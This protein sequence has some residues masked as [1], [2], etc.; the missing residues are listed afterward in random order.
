MNPTLYDVFRA[1]RNPSVFA[2]GIL[3]T[4]LAVVVLALVLSNVAQNSSN[5]SAA[6]TGIGIDVIGGI[7]GFFV[8][9]IGLVIGNAVYAKDRSTGVM[10]SVLCRP[11]TR[12]ELVISRFLALVLSS[13][14]ILAAALFVTDLAVVARTGY[15]ID[16]VALAAIFLSLLV[17]AASFGGL[18]MF[19]SHVFRSGST[20]Q[21]A[22]TTI[23]VIFSIVWYI[24]LIIL[25]AAEN[26]LTDAF[27]T[28]FIAD[29][30]SPAQYTILMTA[31]VQHTFLFGI[32][33]IN[34]A[35][36]G[37]VLGGLVAGGLAW[38]LG[39]FA[40]TYY[41]ATHRD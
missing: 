27:Q 28:M 31:Y 3:T 19:L 21:G 20:V 41:L 37:L 7:F 34:P 29:Y 25:V 17:E 30:F 32:L 5:L 10:D 23:F 14:A 2:M 35:N 11:V 15:F 9:V 4:L 18:I 16:P 8:P 13:G 40:A 26:N 24:A 36:A 1:L 33:Q 38:T 6:A 12:G 22:S 39:P